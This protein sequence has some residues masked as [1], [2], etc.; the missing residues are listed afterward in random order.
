MG[1]QGPASCIRLWF[2]D[3]DG[4]LGANFLKQSA[5]FWSVATLFF[6]ASV[7]NVG[8][9]SGGMIHFSSWP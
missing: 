8:G 2:V 7:K 4:L 5:W 1:F 6:L 3:V 9:W